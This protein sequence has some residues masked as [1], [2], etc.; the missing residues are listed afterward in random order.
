MIKRKISN[1]D[2]SIEDNPK[3]GNNNSNKNRSMG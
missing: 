3:K 1:D 2:I